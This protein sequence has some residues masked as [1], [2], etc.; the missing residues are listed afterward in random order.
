[1]SYFEECLDKTADLI[2]VSHPDYEQVLSAD[3][4]TAHAIETV[5]YEIQQNGLLWLRRSPAVVEVVDFIAF[6]AQHLDNKVV[7]KVYRVFRR[8][9]LALLEAGRFGGSDSD[10]ANQIIDD[11]RWSGLDSVIIEMKYLNT[12][13]AQMIKESEQA[14]RALSKKFM[15]EVEVIFEEMKPKN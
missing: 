13:L 9:M 4:L 10:D 3:Q 5:N 6:L 12:R 15:A 1:M 8:G 7:A 2:G 11:H 14:Y